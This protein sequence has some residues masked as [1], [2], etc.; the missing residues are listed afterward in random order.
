MKVYTSISA[1]QR[2][3]DELGNP[4]GLN[5]ALT[6][7][8]IDALFALLD[9]ETVNF[10]GYGIVRLMRVDALEGTDDE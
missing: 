6:A 3:R 1:M 2:A 7:T 4:S 5:E 8:G 10:S 9:G